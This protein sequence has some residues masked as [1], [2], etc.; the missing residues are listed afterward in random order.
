MHVYPKLPASLSSVYRSRKCFVRGFS[1]SLKC[2]E[3]RELFVVG[4]LPL[5]KNDPYITFVAD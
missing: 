1:F 5:G 2:K 4:F 3:H